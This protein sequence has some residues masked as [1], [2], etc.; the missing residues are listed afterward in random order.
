MTGM[1][2]RGE[3]KTSLGQVH[4]S[5]VIDSLMNV[6]CRATREGMLIIGAGRRGTVLEASTSP[7]G[8][9]ILKSAAQGLREKLI[10][11]RGR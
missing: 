11:L 10:K 6:G 1:R 3:K 9:G 4:Y 2:H 7:A 5:G 8:I